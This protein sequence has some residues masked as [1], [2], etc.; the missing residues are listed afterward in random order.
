VVRIWLETPDAFFDWLEVRKVSP[1][2]RE[3][4]GRSRGIALGPK[5]TFPICLPIRSTS[6]PWNSAAD[7]KAGRYWNYWRAKPRAF[8]RDEA[9]QIWAAPSLPSRP[10]K[11]SFW[12]FSVTSSACANSATPTPLPIVRRPHAAWFVPYLS[13]EQLGQLFARFGAATFGMRAG[14]AAQNADP[15]LENELS[16]RGLDA[17]Q[18]AYPRYTF[19]AVIEPEDAWGD[20][21]ERRSLAQ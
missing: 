18:T 21:V 6:R 13:T 20:A 8:A 11:C 2:F 3:S 19:C 7:T 5:L 1:E 9:A 15:A 17:Y 16:L 12:I 4:L 10:R 14:P